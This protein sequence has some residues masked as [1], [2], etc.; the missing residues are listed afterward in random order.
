MFERSLGSVCT[1]S[2][3]AVRFYYQPKQHLHYSLYNRK[4]VFVTAAWADLTEG[5]KADIHKFVISAC[6]L[7][8]QVLQV[9][10]NL[11]N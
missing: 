10:K 5:V 4:N 3:Q 2:C 6:L 11:T 9:N 7:G 1:A 8:H